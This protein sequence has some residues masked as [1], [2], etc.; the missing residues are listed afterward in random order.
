MKKEQFESMNNMEEEEE[1][2]PLP[3][4]PIIV[5]SSL[6]SRGLKTPSPK[7]TR[8]KGRR[9][10]RSRSKSKPKLDQSSTPAAA[11][12]SR[13]PPPTKKPKISRDK[14]HKKRGFEVP[15]KVVKQE[16]ME[17]EDFV[18]DN[19]KGLES[20]DEH[21]KDFIPDITCAPKRPSS[22]KTPGGGKRRGR[23]RKLKFDECTDE[24]S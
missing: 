14:T 4:I 12:P 24:E 15:K 11:T 19:N 23:P 20:E 9:H 8:G 2:L 21:D 13:I 6:S 10:R 18:E 16:P 1:S 7:K 22:N 5:T 17:I 3:P